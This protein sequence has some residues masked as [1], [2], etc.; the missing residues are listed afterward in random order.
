[1]EVLGLKEILSHLLGCILDTLDIITGI[2]LRLLAVNLSLLGLQF[3]QLLVGLLVDHDFAAPLGDGPLL[4]HFLMDDLDHHE[5]FGF[6][7]EPASH[8]AQHPAGVPT[9][10]SNPQAAFAVGHLHDIR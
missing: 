9:T 10:S 6:L 1:M 7:A 2:Q 8:L 4:H 5:S 3:G